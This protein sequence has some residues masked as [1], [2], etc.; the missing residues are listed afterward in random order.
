MSKFSW[1]HINWFL[2]CSVFHEDLLVTNLQKLTRQK[3]IIYRSKT[4][5]L[6]Q[7]GGKRETFWPGAY[8]Q[9]SIFSTVLT[10]TWNYF[11]FFFFIIIANLKLW[12]QFEGWVLKKNP[13]KKKLTINMQAIYGLLC[14]LNIV[15]VI[16]NT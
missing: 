15:D 6:Y 7:A 9:D 5:T 1:H 10:F 2:V 12:C 3:F 13:L 8:F 4:L 14:V 16:K 11:T